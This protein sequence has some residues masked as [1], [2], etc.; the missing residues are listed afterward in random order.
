MPT[1]AHILGTPE[2]MEYDVG[3]LSGTLRLTALLSMVCSLTPA[4][5]LASEPT[6]EQEVR[7]AEWTRQGQLRHQAWRA[8]WQQG[9]VTQ[10][11]LALASDMDAV[12]RSDRLREIRQL[13]ELPIEQAFV[14]RV[15]MSVVGRDLPAEEGAA[16]VARL[17]AEIEVLDADNALTW[18]EALPDTQKVSPDTLRL[19][20]QRLQQIADSPRVDTGGFVPLMRYFGTAPIQP[21]THSDAMVTAVVISSQTFPAFQSLTVWCREQVL[22]EVCEAAAL[23]LTRDADTM[24]TRAIGLAVLTRVA[25]TPERQAEVATW[26]AEYDTLRAS[27][28]PSPMPGEVDDATLDAYAKRWF[29]AYAEPDATE[30]SAVRIVDAAQVKTSP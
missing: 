26:R 2:T 16:I 11:W 19:A 8:A 24:L 14:A 3:I 9:D 23:K 12:E 27:I 1:A 6:P 28:S 5:V 15:A 29:E 25:S 4:A 13:A 10:R 7:L 21:L 20:R 22:R 30:F 17:R 18:V